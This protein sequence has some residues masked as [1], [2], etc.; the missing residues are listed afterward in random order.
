MSSAVAAC[1]LGDDAGLELAARERNRYEDLVAD[2]TATGNNYSKG[3]RRGAQPE[4]N[5]ASMARRRV[6]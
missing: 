1:K 2:K 5:L 3:N 4:L 6:D